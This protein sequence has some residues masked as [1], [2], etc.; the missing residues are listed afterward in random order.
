MI[1]K[2]FDI[3]GMSCAA[4]SSAVERV[5]G[6][7]DSVTMHSV[8]LT[9]GILTIT[10]DEDQLS[11]EAIIKKVERA[12]FGAS[13][14]ID[15]NKQERKEEEKKKETEVDRTRKRLTA[16][17]ILAIPL[18]Y[19]SMGHML[20]IPLPLPYILD[21]H[22]NPL[23]FALAQL[24]FTTVILYNG[25]RFY[26]SGFQ[27][28]FKG[29]PNM[30]SLVALGTGSA[31]LYSLVMTIAIPGDSMHVHSLYYESA[32]IVVTLVMVGKYME[33]RSKNKTSEAIRKLMELAPDTAILIKDGVQT[34]VPVEQVQIGEQILI[35]P[36]SRIPLDGVIVSGETTVDESM[37]TG[38][39]IPVEK[40]VGD[41]L[42]GGSVNYQGAAT[43]AVTRVGSDTTLAKIVKLMEDAQG[44]KAP[45]SK[46]ADTVAGYFV[47]T[48]MVIAILAAIV[49]A[50]L[51]HDLAFVLTIFVSVLVIACPCALG[52][53]T[54]T[55]IMVGT[56]LG[57]GNGILIKSG[58]ALEITHKADVVVLDK[59]GTITEGKPAV[60]EIVYKD[61]D[62]TVKSFQNFRESM[63]LD[64]RARQL[65]QLAA[66]MEQVSEHPLGQ[67]IV[68]AAAQY[69]ISLTAVEKFQST[70]GQGIEAQLNDAFYYIGN[71]KLCEEKGL[72]IGTFETYAKELAGKGQTPMYVADKTT[73]VIGLISVADPVKET[74][75]AAVAHM[76]ELGI[77]VYM[78]TGDNALTAEYIGS[79]VGVDKV[80]SEVLPQDKASIVEELQK[81]GKCVLMVGD[82]INDA[83]ALVQADVGAAIGSGSDIAID[84]GD[85]VLMKSDL[86]DVYKA[87]KLSKAT[88]RN[89]K[90]NL[91]WA[92]FYNCC[93]IP[94][95]AGLFYA[96]NGT[97]L[98][99]VFAGLA[100]SLS[101]VTVVGNALRLRSL[102]L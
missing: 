98:S 67:A 77:Q 45:I 8:N 40:N 76:Q 101:S 53:A 26:I 37:L 28:L 91:F 12:G 75:R 10:F 44:R 80:I 14:H 31:Y 87:I 50:L 41:E 13:L 57:A 79:Q 20:P 65:L 33:G 93:G 16:N 84:S 27:N 88:I 32:A 55:A 73:G 99:P 78:L 46:L 56:G 19:I 39:S 58:E 64:E 18:L 23:Y 17:I 30:D 83:P 72:A 49:W 90:Q 97:L 95:A 102:K 5:T 42:I 82:G 54:P 1:T 86:T 74:S 7:L 2:Q 15:R 94:L 66:S 63:D 52:L 100:M 36:G 85:I 29:H 47:P 70:T 61:M 25:R 60:V 68:A 22:E 92:F 89:I 62:G 4:C 21:M 34:E 11:D 69:K 48:V 38:E 51:G 59:T 24:I 6:K 81:S 96:L 71:R 9:T 35:K 3:T 43:V